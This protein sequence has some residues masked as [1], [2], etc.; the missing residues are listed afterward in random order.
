MYVRK[1]ELENLRSFDSAK[2]ELNAPGS[3]I[4]PKLALDNVNLLLG[5]NG[6]G[7]TT[8]LRAVALA[9]LSP[10]IAG[11]SGYVPYLLVRRAGR[12]GQTT[13]SRV[14]VE[15]D[16]HSTD[17][18]AAVDRRGELEV[19][20][21]MTRGFIDRFQRPIVPPWAE[22]M[23]EEKAPGFLVL[24]YGASRRV[25]PGSGLTDEIRNKSRALRYSRVAGLFEET[26]TMVSLSSWLRDLRAEAQDRHDEVI[27]LINRVLKPHAELLT[28][29]VDREYLF[30]VG[31]PR[32]PFGALSDGY[33]AF[34]GW[35]TDL[36]YH[37]AQAKPPGFPLDRV[38]GVVLV[39]EVDLHLHPEWQQKVIP[40]VARALPSLQFIFT[41][42]SPLVVGSV[43]QPNVFVIDV[44]NENGHRSSR[45]RPCDE[46]TYG[47]SADQILTG[48]TFGLR[49][50]R[51]EE[52]VATLEHQ[53]SAARAGDAEAA[54]NF[55]RMMSLGGAAIDED[56]QVE[57]ASSDS[58]AK[59]GRPLKLS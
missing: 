55:L 4:A 3:P 32:V 28:E 21:E 16:L 40:T 19:R 29:P 51:S 11:G 17:G 45:A 47:K 18:V 46:E 8:L 25:D 20:L 7:K 35:I 23:W 53:A 59:H 41:S 15:L 2:L 44:V 42:H 56:D 27:A 37:V 10:V 22:D 48:G 30:D 57:P 24:G 52:F 6:S 34:V 12:L 39:D 36:L 31:G 5:D 14:R 49:S 33:R 50:S 13:R 43:W 26:V 1:L 38:P 54:I 58:G 9:A